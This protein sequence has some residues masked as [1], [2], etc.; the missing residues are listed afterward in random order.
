MT[1]SVNTF[2][3]WV[4][5]K[6]CEYV[7]LTLGWCVLLYLFVGFFSVGYLMSKF[8]LKNSWDGPPKQLGCKDE[9]LNMLAEPKLSNQ[10]VWKKRGSYTINDT[11]NIEL[12]NHLNSQVSLILHIYSNGKMKSK[13]CLHFLHQCLKR[14][15]FFFL[16]NFISRYVK[17]YA[18]WWYTR[19]FS[20]RWK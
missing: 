14:K 20:H 10:I 9:F 8:K 12:S 11:Q 13:F 19:W 2:F 5:L 3:E 16:E 17:W 15:Q 6:S 7:R 1:S 18:R 4:K